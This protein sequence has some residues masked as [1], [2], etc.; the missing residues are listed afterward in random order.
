MVSILTASLNKQ[1]KENERTEC[2]P[3]MNEVR[4]VAA[5]CRVICEHKCFEGTYC[6]HPHINHGDGNRC[7]IET[8]VSNP[9]LKT[10]KT[11]RNVGIHLQNTSTLKMEV[12]CSSE[13][14][15]STSETILSWRWRQRFHPKRWYP[16]PRHSNPEDVCRILQ[17]KL[18][19][20]S[21][22]LQP[23]SNTQH[24]LSKRWH[25]LPR[26]FDSD[27]GHR[28]FLRNVGIN[29]Q[30]TSVLKTEKTCYAIKLACNFKILR[31]YRWRQNVSIHLVFWRWRQHFHRNAGRYR[32]TSKPKMETRFSQM[33][34]FISQ[35][36][37][38]SHSTRLQS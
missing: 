12:A 38:V 18:V 35:E 8:L 2:L 13:T 4:S 7:S 3:K 33:L 10:E 19:S 17:Q 14:F 30:E 9:T 21:N 22:T 1:H 5:P 37:M 25:Q 34:V 20:T 27:D 16:F 36:H 11:F 24:I 23:W 6:R 31:A 29:L 26:H 28:M 15:I 32:D